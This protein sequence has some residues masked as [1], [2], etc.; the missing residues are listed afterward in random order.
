MIKRLKQYNLEYISRLHLYVLTNDTVYTIFPL[1]EVNNC[2]LVH[3]KS[4]STNQIALGSPW[5]SI[6]NFIDTDIS[7]AFSRG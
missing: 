2:I 4:Y 6:I 1:K 7:L 5:V 3:E